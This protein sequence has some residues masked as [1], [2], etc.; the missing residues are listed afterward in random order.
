MFDTIFG[1]SRGESLIA[2]GSRRLGAP[3]RSKSRR[4]DDNAVEPPKAFPH[5]LTVVRVEDRR[6]WLP[7]IFEWKIENT[8]YVMPN[9]LRDSALY[10]PAA[11]YV[12]SLLANDKPLYFKAM[13]H[14][15]NELC[16][17]AVD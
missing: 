15:V 5:F 3:P 6:E 7:Q 8:Q 9:T 11:E 12:E 13:N 17:I 4:S 14:H 16:A 1:R 10:R 2:L